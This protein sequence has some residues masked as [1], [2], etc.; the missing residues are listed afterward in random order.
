MQ[1]QT[2]S[3]YSADKCSTLQDSTQQIVYLEHLYIHMP[4]KTDPD[5]KQKFIN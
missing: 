3:T 5:H 2:L 4:L 1:N